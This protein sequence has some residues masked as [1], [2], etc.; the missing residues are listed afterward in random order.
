MPITP[1][2]PFSPFSNPGGQG[3]RREKGASNPRLRL[4]ARRG[5]TL[6][7]EGATKPSSVPKVQFQFITRGTQGDRSWF[8]RLQ[9]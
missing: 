5:V 6:T 8:G 4:K 3:P 2:S 9:A 7:T 1:N